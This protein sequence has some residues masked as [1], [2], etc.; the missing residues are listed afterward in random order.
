[1]KTFLLLLL[2]AAPLQAASIVLDAPTEARVGQL[3]RLDVSKS[4]ADHYK[5]LVFPTTKD[6]EVLPDGQRAFFSARAPGKYQ[7]TIAGSDSEGVDVISFTITV[8]T[9]PSPPTTDSLTEWIEYWRYE[10]D[11]PAKEC[12]KLGSNFLTVADSITDQSP[13]E[14]AKMTATLNREIVDIDLL[15]PLRV[16]ISKALRKMAEEG[17]LSTPEDHIRVWREIAQGL[18]S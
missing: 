2:L 7:F 1:M 5:W 4:Q 12:H 11:L 6:F 15:K 8:Q 3:V 10:F 17:S 14:I 13:K 18:M 9:P 16:K